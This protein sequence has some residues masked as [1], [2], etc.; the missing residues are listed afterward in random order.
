MTEKLQRGL[1]L[2]VIDRGVCSKQHPVPLLF[3]HGAWHAAWCWDRF[4]DYFAENGYRAL[5]VSLRGHGSSPSPR[6]VSGCSLADYVDDV[7]SVVE[8]LQSTPVLIGH[9]MGGF[10]VQKYLEGTDAP[11]AVLIASA[12][13]QGAR[14]FALFLLR[15]YPWLTVRNLVTRDAAHGFNTPAIARDLFFSPATPESDVRRYAAMIGNESR[16]VALDTV[17]RDALRPERITTSILVMGAALDG[18]ITL[19]EVHDTARAYGTDAEIFEGIGHNMM[20]DD[21]WAMVAERIHSWL[22]ERRL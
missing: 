2:E 9:S 13:P 4:L 6:H 17:K 19:E 12:P 16:R 5:A 10:V 14:R 22:G 8:S 21:G 15:R 18:C 20:L 1:E 7:K 11:A 3:V